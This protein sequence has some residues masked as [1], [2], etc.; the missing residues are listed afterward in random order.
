MRESRGE[1]GFRGE[2]LLFKVWVE[3]EEGDESGFKSWCDLGK[4]KV[5]GDNVEVNDYRV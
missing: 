5:N 1:W 2:V 3:E 4:W